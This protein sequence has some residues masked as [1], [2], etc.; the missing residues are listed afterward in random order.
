MGS[1]MKRKMEESRAGEGAWSHHWKIFIVR[2]VEA[3]TKAQ[4]KFN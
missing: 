4:G 2:T 1:N 3:Q